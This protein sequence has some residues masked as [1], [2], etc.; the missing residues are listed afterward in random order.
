MDKEEGISGQV[1]RE[2]FQ[3][4]TPALSQT[5]LIDQEE[6]AIAAQLCC[7]AGEM[8]GI[9]TQL[10]LPVQQLQQE[11]AVCGAAAKTAADRD[12]FVQVDMNEGEVGEI[13]AQ[14]APG[15]DREV[16]IGITGNGATGDAKLQV[17]RS[18]CFED[19]A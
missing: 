9:Q 7:V 10:E 12:L 8:P 11:R 16:V 15:P 1:K 18:D 3:L 6:G 14:Q 13:V 19:I 4:F 2:G 17:G 5:G